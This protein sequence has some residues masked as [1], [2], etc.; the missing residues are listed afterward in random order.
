MTEY[1]HI[2]NHNIHTTTRSLASLELQASSCSD[3]DHLAQ[4]L[5]IKSGSSKSSSML[6]E[7]SGRPVGASLGEAPGFNA[8]DLEPVPELADA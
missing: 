3:S 6:G 4:T 7:R 8:G 2:T 1:Q 5:G